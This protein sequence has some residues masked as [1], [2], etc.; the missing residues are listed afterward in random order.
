MGPPAQ[1]RAPFGDVTIEG[2]GNSAMTPVR[3][4]AADPIIEEIR[5]VKRRLVARV[6]YDAVK[7]LRDAQK[8]QARGSTRDIKAERF[9]V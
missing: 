7:M 6:G 2:S 4:V 8:R 9:G 5:D 1:P 3:A